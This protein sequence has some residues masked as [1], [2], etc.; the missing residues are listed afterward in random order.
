LGYWGPLRRRLGVRP[1]WGSLLPPAPARADSNPRR[2][3]GVRRPCVRAEGGAAGALFS[4]G[5]SVDVGFTFF[6]GGAVPP[7]SWVSR[8]SFPFYY[9][10]NEPSVW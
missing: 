10:F 6:F 2:R 7:I 4:V 3:R 8:V 5:R 1:H 9:T